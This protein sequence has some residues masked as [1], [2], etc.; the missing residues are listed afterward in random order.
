MTTDDSVT[1]DRFSTLQTRA[2]FTTATAQ[3]PAVVPIYQTA[4]YEFESFA[5]A[6]AIFA[7][8][9][10]GNLYS[11]TGNPT[12]TVLEERVAALDG[13]VAALA[14]ASGQSAVLV[15]LLAL[16]KT[17]EHIVAA[18]QLYGGTLDLLTDTFADFGID[19]TL[20][21]QNDLEA[22]RAAVRPTTRAFFAETITNPTASVLDVQAVADIAHAAG[23]P[24]I[25]DNTVAT[26]Y[27]QRPKEFGAD[28]VVYSATKFLGGHGSS[29]AGVIV[30]LGTFDFGAD[31]ARWPQFTEPFERVGDVVL[32]DA[33][34]SARS[35]YLVYAKVKLVHDL[36]P[37]LSPFNSFQIIQGLET[38]D[39]RVAK[40]SAN[41]LA[42]AAFLDSHPA[43]S[44]VR[45]P[46]LPDDPGYE[47]ARRY[48][49]RG[50]GSVFSFDLVSGDERV[51]EF[52]DSLR[53]F[54]LVANI[55]DARSLVIHPATTTHSH[56]TDHDLEGAGFTRGTVRVS[57]G[58][59]DVEDLIADL[60]SSL[61]RL[62]EPAGL[63]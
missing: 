11:R 31:R 20:V 53:V 63:L 52:I 14:T 3:N 39:L 40:H 6:R 43:V 12:Q 34:G 61:T 36:G 2:G 55:G 26:P 54:K 29:L 23:V 48:L 27:L 25:V 56:L 5:A 42:V 37:A 58:L 17:G 22:W 15:S 57:I 35:A 24:L 59:E 41:A 21:D 33:F 45:Y 18:R 7:L 32:W 51:E 47:A 62:L 38:L 19:V 10:K 8:E 46:G 30:D 50:A 60:D 49:P 13:G 9:R 1:G 44:L 28:I 4:A 16:A